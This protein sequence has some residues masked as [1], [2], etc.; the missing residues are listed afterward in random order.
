M[1]ASRRRSDGRI[2]R[3]EPLSDELM[4]ALNRVQMDVRGGV[5][6]QALKLLLDVPEGL[7]LSG[8][9]LQELFQ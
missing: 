5:G 3:D 4:V 6:S 8:E 9:C 7:V 2:L 1:A